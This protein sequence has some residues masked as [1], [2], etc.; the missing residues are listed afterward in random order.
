M[1]LAATRLSRAHE[2]ERRKMKW[3]GGGSLTKAG[4]KYAIKPIFMTHELTR[5]NFFH[6]NREARKQMDFDSSACSRETLK[7]FFLSNFGLVSK[8]TFLILTF[9]T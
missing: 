4:Y 1:C 6:V 2:D 3:G 8:V 7:Q 5:D 9:Q